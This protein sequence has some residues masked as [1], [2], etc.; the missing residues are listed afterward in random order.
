MGATGEDNPAA[1]QVGGGRGTPGDW[2]H[3]SPTCHS[4]CRTRRSLPSFGK[5]ASVLPSGPFRHLRTPPHTPDERRPPP[6]LPLTH[7][8]HSCT[9]QFPIPPRPAPRHDRRRPSL[10]PPLSE[11]VLFCGC[12]PRSIAHLSL[13]P[14]PTW[15]PLSA[16]DLLCDQ[17][18]P[19]SRPRGQPVRRAHLL[20]HTRFNRTSPLQ[21]CGGAAAAW[22]SGCFP[23][24][25]E[26]SSESLLLRVCVRVGVC[27]GVEGWRSGWERDGGRWWTLVPWVAL[28]VEEEAAL[29][30]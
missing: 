6:P 16:G 9:F 27:G 11:S 4:N 21:R 17:R 28:A 15:T 30:R 19:L 13:L 14:A 1:R 29:A 8:F 23:C 2:A 7:T 22:V 10:C 26:V 12:L 18:C 3:L 24:P 5:G 25:R 20:G